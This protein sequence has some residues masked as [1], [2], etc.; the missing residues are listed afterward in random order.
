VGLRDVDQAVS[1][2]AVPEDSNPIDLDWP[3][4]DMP[5]LQPGAAHPCP[6]PFDDEV[7]FQLGDR[8]DDD[9]DGASQRAARIDALPE[10]DEFDIQPVQLIQHFEEVPDRAGDPV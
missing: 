6:H 5:A 3:P 2:V 8:P 10:A 4:A 1:P 7:A 9:D